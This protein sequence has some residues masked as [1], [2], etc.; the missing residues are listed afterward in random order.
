M[1]LMLIDYFEQ[2]Y[3]QK[4]EVLI[5]LDKKDPKAVE[6]I[7][8]KYIISLRDRQLA[9]A[10]IK[11]R[12]AAITAFLEL[13]DVTVNNKKLKRFIGEHKKT[14]KDQAYTHEDLVKMFQHAT[15][16]AKLIIAIYSSTGI[17]KGAIID[18][19]LKHLQK[20]ASHNLSLYKFTIYENTNDEYVTFCT[21]ECATMIDEYLAQRRAAGE[22]IN[23][24]ESY[25][26]RNDF[27]FIFK[28]RVKSPR[29]TSIS[30]L[31]VIM[32]RI[33]FKT[34][35]RQVNYLTENSRYKRHS[36]AGFHAFR[37]YFNT[38]L[39]SCDVNLSIKE[40]LMGHSASMGLDGSYFRPT[41]KQLLTEYLKAVNEL[42]INEENRLRKK[43]ETLESKQSEID[44]MKLKHEMEMKGI[45][46]QLDRLGNK[47]LQPS[48][49]VC[50]RCFHRRLLFF[51]SEQWTT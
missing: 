42:T 13:N 34:E 25:L 12:L 26:I 43:V 50:C 48:V 8:I 17:R 35:L 24:Q 28:T 15:F 39:A 9:Y 31:N 14:V 7:L 44:Q 40:C 30:A 5:Q 22:I 49:T 51:I 33:L 18:L 3:K 10:S 37:K 41:E 27:D 16:R 19:K 4:I 11:V 32:N 45:N 29:K 36:K 6:E 20:I 47:L 38:C 1:Y 21:P 46:A 2:W 23:S